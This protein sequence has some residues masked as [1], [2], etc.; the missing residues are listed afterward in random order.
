MGYTLVDLL[1]V[2]AA[3]RL[4]RLITKDDFPPV[5][6]VRDRIAGG[7]RNLTATEQ[8]MLF[9]GVLPADKHME[10]RKTWSVN[11]EGT[12]RYVYRWHRVP[13]WLADLVSCPWCASAYVSGTLVLLFDLYVPGGLPVPYLHG[14][15]VWAGASLLASREWA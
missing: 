13:D 3:Y 15:A 12:Q 6:W 8:R 5:L 14:V 9:G 11:K 4:T 7:W 10:L 1:L 2:A